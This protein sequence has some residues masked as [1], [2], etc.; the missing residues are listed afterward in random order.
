MARV[1]GL[2]LL[3]LLPCVSA[4]ATTHYRFNITQTRV[5][6]SMVQLQE[7]RLYANGGR[8]DIGA[9]GGTSSNP[10][11]SNPNPQPVGNLFDGD[12]SECAATTLLAAPPLPR[13]SAGPVRHSPHPPSPILQ[14][15]LHVLRAVFSCGTWPEHDAGGVL[16]RMQHLHQGHEVA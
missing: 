3:A 10:G 6:G 5:P 11:G 15:Q 4:F 9:L 16:P 14:V 12:V 8:L 2:A 13:P 1:Q 7:I